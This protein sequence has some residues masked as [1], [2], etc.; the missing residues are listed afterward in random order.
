MVFIEA[1][2]V[3]LTH[4][5]LRKEIYNDILEAKAMVDFSKMLQFACCTI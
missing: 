3:L 2:R 4:M 5:T 1:S